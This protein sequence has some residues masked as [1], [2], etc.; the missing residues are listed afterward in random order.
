MPPRNPVVRAA[1]AAPKRSAGRHADKRPEPPIEL[2]VA[3]DGHLWV[4]IT[5]HADVPGSHLVLMTQPKEPT[6]EEVR[7][8]YT[9]HGHSRED[10]KSIRVTHCFGMDHWLEQFDNRRAI[11]RWIAEGGMS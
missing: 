2:P 7:R 4:V 1:I 5:E 3:P 9:K 8:F 11:A 10:V 6:D